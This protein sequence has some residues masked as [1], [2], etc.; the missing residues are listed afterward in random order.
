M[1]K[2]I[3]RNTNLTLKVKLIKIRV[4][5]MKKIKKIQNAHR[6]EK[7]IKYAKLKKV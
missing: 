6:G 4:G 1:Y 7:I 5:K 3:L 2:I